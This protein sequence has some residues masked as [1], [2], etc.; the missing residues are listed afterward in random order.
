VPV[1]DGRQ[2][3]SAV[4]REEILRDVHEERLERKMIRR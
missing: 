4:R 1:S 2:S 3:E